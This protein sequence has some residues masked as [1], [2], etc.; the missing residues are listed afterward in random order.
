QVRLLD[1]GVGALEVEPGGELALAL[2]DGVAHFLA[3]DLGHDVERRHGG[4]PTRP[5]HSSTPG[6]VPEWPKGADCKSAG[7]AYGRSNPPRP[8]V[9]DYTIDRGFGVTQRMTLLAQAHAPGTVS[10]LDMLGVPRDGAR[11]VDLGCGGG[12]VTMELARRV[13]ASGRV[14][15]I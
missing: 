4:D 5:L 13:G 1:R 14:V 7:T 3:I 10:V 8:T 12:H 6:S 2:V 15:G 11:C 9:S